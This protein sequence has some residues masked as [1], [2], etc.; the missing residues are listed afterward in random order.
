MNVSRETP[1]EILIQINN[2][3]PSNIDV[4]KVNLNTLKMD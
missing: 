1:D 2:S 4:C 3:D